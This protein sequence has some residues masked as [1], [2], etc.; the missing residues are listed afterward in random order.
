[1]SKFKC[2]SCSWCCKIDKFST[3]EEFEIARKALADLGIQLTG[4]KVKDFILWPKT[5]PALKD[6]RCLIYEDRPYA[7]R[8]FLCGKQY[9][10]DTRP[11]R[12]DGTFN[13]D[14]FN[15]QLDNIPEFAKVKETMENEAAIWGMRRGWNLKKTG[16]QSA[17]GL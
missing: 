8:Q 11:W 17:R 16:R 15:W 9:K 10:R 3:P 14:Y 7:C 12:G 1:M 4:S 6:N 5:C 2:Y 13:M